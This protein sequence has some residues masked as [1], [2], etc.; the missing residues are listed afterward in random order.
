M[1]LTH[2]HGRDINAAWWDYY[3]GRVGLLVWFDYY[4]GRVGLLLSNIFYIIYDP[5]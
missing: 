2:W 5:G 4:C 3:C 1:S